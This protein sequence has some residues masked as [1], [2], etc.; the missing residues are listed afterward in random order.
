MVL[1]H[2]IFLGVASRLWFPEQG[3]NTGSLHWEQGEKYHIRAIHHFNNLPK[4]NKYALQ[5]NMSCMEPWLGLWSMAEIWDSPSFSSLQYQVGKKRDKSIGSY[6]QIRSRELKPESLR[7]THKARA[8][9]QRSEKVY[10]EESTISSLT[11]QRRPHSCPKALGSQ[12]HLRWKTWCD[13]SRV[14]S[15]PSN[16]P[17]LKEALTRKAFLA[18]QGINKLEANTQKSYTGNYSQHVANEL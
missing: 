6:S 3:L 4:K 12:G 15:F 17:P 14:F 18:V 11:L 16:W 8:H 1:A 7:I 9:M 2:K 13:Q 5:E 10:S